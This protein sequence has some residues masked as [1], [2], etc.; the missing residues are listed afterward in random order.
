MPFNEI[1]I[2]WGVPLDTK[3]DKLDISI[4]QKFLEKNLISITELASNRIDL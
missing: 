4:Q 3:I 1:C 2:V